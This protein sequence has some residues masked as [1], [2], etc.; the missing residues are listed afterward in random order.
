MSVAIEQ[1]IAE[2]RQLS[3]DERER[4]VE[5]WNASQYSDAV[6]RHASDAG[7]AEQ[8]RGEPDTR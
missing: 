4:L 2:L 6:S 3:S 7:M 1:L 5:Y 8:L